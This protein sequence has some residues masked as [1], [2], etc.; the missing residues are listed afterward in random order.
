MQTP[1]SGDPWLTEHDSPVEIEKLHLPGN[2]L[3]G[4]LLD[5]FAE[6]EATH[7][8]FGRDWLA[9]MASH[10]LRMHETAA[11]YVARNAHGSFIALPLKLDSRTGQAHSLG[12]FYTSAYSPVIHAAAPEPLFLALFQ[13]LALVEKCTALTISP[14]NRSSHVYNLLK[15]AI[16]QSDWRDIHEYD[17]FKN[18][19]HELH[20]ANYEAYLQDR[21]SRLRN[22]ITRRTR[23][24]MK[25]NRGQIALVRGGDSLEEAIEQFVSVYN[26]SWKQV[27]P[28]PDFIPQLLRLAARR[29]WLRL[30]IASY[31]DIPVA[32]QI[33]LIWEQTA[34]IFKLAHGE[35]FKRLSP[36]TVL[37]AYMMEQ[38]IDQDHV[39]RIDFLSGDDDYKR[40]WMTI[41]NDFGGIAAYNPRTLRGKAM[42]A[43]RQM[44]ALIKYPQALR[45]T[46]T[47]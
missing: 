20:G 32:G 33:W 30:G 14:M 44:K 2:D 26:E 7:L 40:D 47:P 10:A 24:F 15:N 37:T 6:Y 36:G 38:A 9:N 22:T 5:A 12:N 28:F 13:H 41:C 21:P 34:H 4:P 1:V 31:D 27:E 16:N 11:I 42:I 29:G 17:C 39:S 25:D 46:I 23:Q 43:G 18:W 19:I 8:Q 3:A 35:S 45:G